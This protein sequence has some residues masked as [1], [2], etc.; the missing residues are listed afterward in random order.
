MTFKLRFKDMD[1]Y[2][3]GSNQGWDVDLDAGTV[4]LVDPENPDIYSVNA[5]EWL[6]GAVL[7]AMARVADDITIEEV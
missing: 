2:T 7:V 4:F 5:E 3:I 6:P 1:G